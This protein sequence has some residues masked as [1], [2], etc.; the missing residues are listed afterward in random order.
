MRKSLL[1]GLATLILLIGGCGIKIVKVWDGH[2]WQYYSFAT[3]PERSFAI[4]AE[5]RSNELEAKLR[6]QAATLAA[7]ESL[8]RASTQPS[9]QPNGTN[10][11]DLQMRYKET[12]DIVKLAEQLDQLN[13]QQLGAF[14]AAL[15][16]LNSNPTSQDNQKE[17]WSTIRQINDSTAQMRILTEKQIT[18]RIVYSKTGAL[19]IASDG[20]ETYV[21][22]L[23]PNGSY[24]SPWV[25][26]GIE[27]RTGDRVRVRASGRIS[28]AFHHIV[29][30]ANGD[31][32]PSHPWIGPEGLDPKSKYPLRN[33]RKVDDYRARGLLMPDASWGCLLG[34]ISATGPTTRPSEPEKVIK[35][36]KDLTLGIEQKGSL[37][38]TVNE[39]WLDAS[40]IDIY[41]PP[42]ADSGDD[43]YDGEVTP[44]NP[45]TKPNGRT[46][47]SMRDRFQKLIV[48]KYYWGVWYDDN[49][50]SF[51][52]VVEV[53]RR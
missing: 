37:Y 44:G 40:M 38:L 15:F 33:L 50:G 11:A 14:K 6:A 27:L 49:A 39:I 13:A 7:A 52:V 1:A 25:N 45:T 3:N 23:S 32:V 30:A 26:T 46:V 18:A 8:A 2:Q 48:D 36:G 51:A 35:V 9:T 20:K 43:Y 12:R 53:E 21:I 16:G 31:T 5:N 28:L 22:A 19:G 41:A 17:F 29:E 10:E 4:I 47:R 24:D 42:L 34:Q